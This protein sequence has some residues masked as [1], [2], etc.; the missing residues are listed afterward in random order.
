MFQNWNLLQNCLI[1]IPE[2]GQQAYF[3]TGQFVLL[4]VDFI[5]QSDPHPSTKMAKVRALPVQEF[6]KL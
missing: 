6:G 3:K 5:Q 4:K 1:F 2:E